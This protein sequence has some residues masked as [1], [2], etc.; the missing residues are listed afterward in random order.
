MSDSELKSRV[1]YLHDAL[2]KLSELRKTTRK[3]FLSDYRIS[4]A[5]L[6]NLQLVIESLTDIG[7][8]ILKRGGQKIAETRVEVFELLCRSGYLDP[9]LEQD[10]V[11]MSRFRNLLVH[12]Y[13]TI[14]LAQ[15]YGILQSRVD[16]FKQVATKLI[17]AA[18]SLG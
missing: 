6:R 14:D 16:L 1:I 15:V 3:E 18:Q 17:E 10:L 9:K 11:L 4:D 12:G 2:R 8:Y 5:T 7:N 13:A